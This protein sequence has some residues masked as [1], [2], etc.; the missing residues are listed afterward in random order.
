MYWYATGRLGAPAHRGRLNSD[1]L[2]SS[3]AAG[4]LGFCVTVSDALYLPLTL[5]PNAIAV[6]EE[7]AGEFIREP[8]V[9]L[10]PVIRS[11]HLPIE[12]NRNGVGPVAR[13]WPILGGPDD[14]V[15]FDTEVVE[16]QGTSCRPL[17]TAHRFRVAMK[18]RRICRE[19]QDSVGNGADLFDAPL[20]V[21]A[22]QLEVAAVFA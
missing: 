13:P 9:S 4:N 8:Q 22:P 7:L 3:S 14:G 21:G 18:R 15:H 10:R 6:S 16:R 11:Q 20:H 12:K 17:G 19:D 2:R 1:S 5:S